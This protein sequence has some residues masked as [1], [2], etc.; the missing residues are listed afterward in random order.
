MMILMMVKTKAKTMMIK[1]KTM[2]MFFIVEGCAKG[3][4]EEEDENR[5][6]IYKL[7]SAAALSSQENFANLSQSIDLH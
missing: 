6:N 4:M 7:L 5:W 2:M 3:G 1:D